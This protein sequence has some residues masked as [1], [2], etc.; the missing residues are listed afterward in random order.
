MSARFANSRWAE[1]GL[2]VGEALRDFVG[3]LSGLPSYHGET[4]LL[5]GAPAGTRP[6][7]GLSR[8]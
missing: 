2:R 6:G 7:R 3:V 1:G 5:D 4:S 8:S